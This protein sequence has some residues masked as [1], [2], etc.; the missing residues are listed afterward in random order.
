ML[1]NISGTYHSCLSRFRLFAFSCLLFLVVAFGCKSSDDHSQIVTLRFWGLGREGEVVSELVKDFEREHPDIRVRVQ[2]VPWSAA[3]EKLLTAFVGKASPDLAQLGNTWIPE[4]ATLKALVPLD[5]AISAS[6]TIDS[7]NFFGGIWRTNQI[8]RV[9]Y[10]IPWYVDTRLVFYRKDILRRAGYQVFPTNWDDWLAAMRAIKRQVGPSRYPIY[11][12]IN[13]WVPAV[14]LGLQAGSPLLKDHDGLGAFSDSA[15]RRGFDYY[16]SIFRDSLAP[17]K[18]L[19]DVAN[20]Y[21]EFER[22]TF[23]MWITGPW[24]LG[25]FRRRLPDS[26]QSSWATAPVPGPTGA[27]SGVSLAGGSSIVIFRSSPHPREAWLLLEFLS[28]P[29]RQR[30]FFELTGDL[31]A[32]TDAWSPEWLAADSNRVSFWTQLQRV[33]PTPLVPEWEQIATM[34]LDHSEQ[35]VRGGVP[36]DQV[37]R[38]LDRNVNALLE[39]RRWMLE[40]GTLAAGSR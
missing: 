2:Q 14:V 1:R 35:A 26:M 11:L 32:R 15:F 24:N 18:G 10:G 13:E 4:F 31:P 36:A 30:R 27:A 33:V 29:E 17:V 37:L 3:H 23:A 6:P 5:S 21:Q 34:V 9:T 38:N 7:S 16:L 20:V 12:P 39:K 22:G 25:E 28:R 8:D 40:H 19:N